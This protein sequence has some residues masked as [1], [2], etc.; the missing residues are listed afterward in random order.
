MDV[1]KQMHVVF[2][3]AK[4]DKTASPLWSMFAN[5]FSA[6]FSILPVNTS[7]GILSPGQYAT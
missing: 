4:L 2:L 1:Y 5:V 7:S 3:T 6:Y